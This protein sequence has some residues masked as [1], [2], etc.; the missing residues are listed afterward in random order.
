M[1]QLHCLTGQMGLSPANCRKVMTAC[2]QFVTMF[3]AKLWQ[4]GDHVHGTMGQVDE[5]QLQVN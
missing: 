3:S 1:A 2:V 5:L 4:N